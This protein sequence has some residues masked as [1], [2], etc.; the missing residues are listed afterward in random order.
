MPEL[1]G[2]CDRILVMREGRIVGEVRGSS[3]TEE[4]LVELAMGQATL[5]GIQTVSGS[6]GLPSEKIGRSEAGFPTLDI[7]REFTSDDVA[8]LE[9]E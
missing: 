1:L 2:L 5:E 6:S 4:R 3:M 8:E 7:G 9:D